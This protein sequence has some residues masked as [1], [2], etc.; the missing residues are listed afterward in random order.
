MFSYRL[1]SRMAKNA[2]ST[3]TSVLKSNAYFCTQHVCHTFGTCCKLHVCS[4]NSWAPVGQVDELIRRQRS[5]WYGCNSRFTM[6]VLAR[7]QPMSVRDS[8]D[9]NYTATCGTGPVSSALPKGPRRAGRKRVTATS[10]ALPRTSLRMPAAAITPQPRLR[11][12][13][14]DQQS[15]AAHFHVTP[16]LPRRQA[17]DQPLIPFLGYIIW[18]PVPK[19][20]ATMNQYWTCRQ[21]GR[22]VSYGARRTASGTS[23]V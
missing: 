3:R 14:A 4:V 19:P 8:G 17:T 22:V 13:M 5:C 1:Y 15:P 6:V 23:D 11:S 20:V 18:K 12:M 10:P 21:P 7:V 16:H 9:R 2:I